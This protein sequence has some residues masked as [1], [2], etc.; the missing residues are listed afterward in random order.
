[1]VM[2]STTKIVQR[3]TEWTKC[4]GIS[5]EYPRK[6][7]LFTNQVQSD[8]SQGQS[9]LSLPVIF[10]LVRIRWCDYSDFCFAFS[11]PYVRAITERYWF[12][13][14]FEKWMVKLVTMLT[15]SLAEI[16]SH[17]SQ[18]SG[19]SKDRLRTGP[20]YSLLWGLELSESARGLQGQRTSACIIS[21]RPP[22]NLSPTRLKSSC[23]RRNVRSLPRRPTR[24]LLSRGK[25]R[26][27]VLSRVFL[28]IRLRFLESCY[29][30]SW[31]WSMIETAR[32]IGTYR[33]HSRPSFQS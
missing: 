21:A 29:P 15:I 16:P 27:L 20:H 25:I 17:E 9:L 31:S 5:S 19:Y 10:N 30:A 14:G 3:I 11:Q 33:P 7:I 26:G 22:T 24:W 12:K 1:M 28:Q 8:A 32:N 2:A 4:R 6:D 18:I 23:G 13:T